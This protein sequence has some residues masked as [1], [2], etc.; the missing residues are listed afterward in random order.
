[1]VKEQV[2]ALNILLEESLLFKEE[3]NIKFMGIIKEIS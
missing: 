1:M 3:N 2:G